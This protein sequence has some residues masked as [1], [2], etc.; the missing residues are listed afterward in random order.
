M[1]YQIYSGSEEA[2]DFMKS[3]TL[4]YNSGIMRKASRLPLICVGGIG[5]TLYGVM[6]TGRTA[7][8]RLA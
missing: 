3:T 6:I 4:P 5:M 7:T 2:D 8:G 1:R